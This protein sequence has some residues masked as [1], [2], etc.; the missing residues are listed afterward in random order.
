MICI[1]KKENNNRKRLACTTLVRPILEYRA[2]CWEP[3]GEGQVSALRWM[4]KR[5]A[6]FV[7]NIN[8]TAK[9]DSPNMRPFPRHT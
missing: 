2:M 6:K 1:L 8:G 7:S 9:I 5:A 4:Q 3:Y